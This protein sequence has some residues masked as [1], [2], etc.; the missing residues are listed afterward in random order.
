M[1]RSRESDTRNFNSC[2]GLEVDRHD[3]SSYSISLCF[4][5]AGDGNIIRFQDEFHFTLRALK[6]ILAFDHFDVDINVSDAWLV[7]EHC[8][9]FLGEFKLYKECTLF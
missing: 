5:F 3:M 4:V 2:N 8:A 1:P 7:T 6:T 9:L